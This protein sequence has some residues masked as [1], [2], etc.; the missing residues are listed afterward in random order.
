MP[1]SKTCWKSVIDS[2]AGTLT[3]KYLSQEGEIVEEVEHSLDDF[4]EVMIRLLA[5]HGWKQRTQD[6]SAGF[7]RVAEDYGWDKALDW[8]Q[9]NHSQ[10]F[11]TQVAGEWSTRGE[12]TLVRVT[13]LME[14]VVRV[15]KQELD[16]V[17]A[18]IFPMTKEDK[19]KLAKSPMIAKEML[20]VKA[21]RA[22]AKAIRA[23][24][25]VIE[26][27]ILPDL[28]EDMPEATIGELGELVTIEKAIEETR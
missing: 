7:A 24:A 18:K 23:E 22:A 21:E 26:D 12:G 6:S 17:V 16:V 9:D 25:L 20:A 8:A 11:K 27:D 3:V 14:A 10:V 2:E 15:Y 13:I 28:F 4:S 5:L 1:K 19:A